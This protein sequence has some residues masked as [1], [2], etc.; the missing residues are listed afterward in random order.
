MTLDEQLIYLRRGMAE[1]IPEED[2]RERLAEAAKSALK[3]P[4]DP[5]ERK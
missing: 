2:L 5:N 4:E 3:K 1:I